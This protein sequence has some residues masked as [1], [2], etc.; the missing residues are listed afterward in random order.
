[1]SEPRRVMVLPC[2]GSEFLSLTP[3]EASQIEAAVYLEGEG[4][5]EG[6]F[7]PGWSSVGEE[8]ERSGGEPVLAMF[9]YEGMGGACFSLVVRNEDGSYRCE[10]DSRDE[11]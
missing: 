2:T 4:G 5:E 3:A 7:L 11:A 10:E 8:F 6:P 1:M 9:E